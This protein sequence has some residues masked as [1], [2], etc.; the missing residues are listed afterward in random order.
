QY[1]TQA[2]AEDPTGNAQRMAFVS[3]EKAYITQYRTQQVLIVNPSAQTEAEFIIGSLDLS[4]YAD[5]DA[6][7]APEASAAMIVD[8][9]LFVVL[10]RLVNYSP[11][12]DGVS[13]YVAVFDTATDT[14]IDT[15]PNDEPSAPKGIELSTRN[16]GKLVYRDGV[17]LFL[18]SIGDAYAS[19]RNGRTPGYTG[20]ISKI[21]T[22]TYSVELIVDDGD[23]DNHPYGFI[24]NLAIVDANNGYFVGYEGWMN[25]SLYHFNPSTGAATAVTAYANIDMRTIEADAAGNL[26]IGIA[27]S[28]SP[29]IEV[30]DGQQSLLRTINLIQNP[31]EILFS[32]M[33]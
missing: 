29:R 12:E 16:P 3:N 13:A 19:S 32:K 7:G 20:G 26:W 5:A 17:G 4:A 14:E 8:G 28:A 21:D 11:A 9:K 30:L 27:D 18:Q 25:T 15:N 10:Q 1:T 33:Q 22:E 31:T 24:S 23:N 2:N 6:N